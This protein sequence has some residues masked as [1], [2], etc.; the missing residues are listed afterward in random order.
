MANTYLCRLAVWITECLTAS[1]PIQVDG[2]STTLG[3]YFLGS[4]T[5]GDFN[6]GVGLAY[7]IVNSVAENR[8]NA[9]RF[10]ETPDAVQIA[11]LAVVSPRLPGASP[12]RLPGASPLHPAGQ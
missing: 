1:T 4:M 6:E 11:R 5:D 3:T 12:P 2:A 7:D 9:K 10:V 8:A